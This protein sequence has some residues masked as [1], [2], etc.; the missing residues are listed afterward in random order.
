MISNTIID[1]EKLTN[2]KCLKYSNTFSFYPIK[3]NKKQLVFQT[4]KLYVPF[5]IQERNDKQYIEL[6]FINKNN[7][8]NIKIFMNNIHKIE[9]KI[10]IKFKTKNII[11]IIK[12]DKIKL[13]IIKCLYFDSHK[14]LIHNIHS[15]IYGKFIINIPGMWEYDNTLFFQLNL[16]QAMVDIPLYL[17][18]FSFIDDENEKVIKK[19]PIP[20]PPPLPIFKKTNNKSIMDI[21]KTT[22]VKKII[23]HEIEYNPPSINDITEALKKM[24]LKMKQPL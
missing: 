2:Q 22:G 18:N 17:T 14:N 4:P 15:N 9:N 7:D 24:K 16:L 8:N 1:L 11:D 12:D 19:K 21:I 6:S 3:Y 23:K 5:G 10:K 13:K 20:P